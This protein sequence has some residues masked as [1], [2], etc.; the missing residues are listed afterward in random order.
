MDGGRVDGGRVDEDGERMKRE[1]GVRLDATKL[2]S[3]TPGVTHK[4]RL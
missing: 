1:N 3:I 2:S 4:K